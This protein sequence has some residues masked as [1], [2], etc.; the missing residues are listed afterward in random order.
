MFTFFIQIMLEKMTK[1][2]KFIS[3]EKLDNKNKLIV[4]VLYLGNHDKYEN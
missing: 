1:R 2:A 3:N 4:P